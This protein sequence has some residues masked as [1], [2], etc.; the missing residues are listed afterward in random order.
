LSCEEFLQLTLL[1]RSLSVLLFY[2]HG[3]RSEKIQKFIEF[4]LQLDL[5]HRCSSKITSKS[6]IYSLYAVIEHSGTIRS[7]HYVAYVKQ[8]MD[9]SDSS[10]DCY[11]K[12]ADDLLR[13]LFSRTVDEQ[14]SD[15]KKLSKITDPS[16]PS[17]SWYH[18]SDNAIHKVPESKV[19]EA[20]AYVLFYQRI[21]NND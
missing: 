8:S 17:S 16:N 6:G 5:T 1:V 12:P 20:D 18:I 15:G 13:H 19:L 4:P 10:D 21:D 11:S 3:S 7:G 2:Q 14:C 9:Y